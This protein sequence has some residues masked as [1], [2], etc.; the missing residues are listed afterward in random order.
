MNKK[1]K[2]FTV[3]DL[4]SGAGGFSLGFKHAGFDVLCGIDNDLAAINTYQK[5]FGSEKGVLLDLSQT[6][7]FKNLEK[8]ITGKVDVIIGGPPCQGFSVAGK[9]IAEDPRNKLYKTYLEFI[10]FY[11]PKAV[12]VENVPSILSL[13]G[14]RI[15]NEIIQDLKN[16]GFSVSV[17]KV[18]AADFG[19]PQSR[20]R[21][22]I[23][24]L[25]VDND[26]LVM[27]PIVTLGQVT[28]G[29]AISD[30]P[31]LENNYGAEELSYDLP[32]LN[33]YQKLM[34]LGSKKIHNHSAV[35]HKPE[36]VKV[37]SLVPDG[38]NY[39]S[40]PEELQNI[41]KVNIA[42]TRL[43]SKK[44]S[45]TIDAGHNHHFH[46]KANR[47]PTVRE[48]ARLQ[49]FPDKFI[50]TGGRVSQYRQVGNA[51]PPLLAEQI[52]IFLKNYIN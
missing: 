23:V 7:N 10:D 49:S 24:G 32:A 6:V 8:I 27:S 28:S 3:L 41:R 44:P 5:N 50:F 29:M 19:V 47:V 31:L 51:V 37:I 22:F 17:H 15:S 38:G 42:W 12:I 30:L 48:S 36:T 46:Y 52:A 21:V 43:N 18:N 11:K 33:D 35:V 40:L 20:K 16:C 45:F 2:Q 1:N 34:R 14:G 26:N 39:K 25:K 4:F 13:Y 9:R